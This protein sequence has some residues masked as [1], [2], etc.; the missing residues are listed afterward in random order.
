MRTFGADYENHNNHRKHAHRSNNLVFMSTRVL[1]RVRSDLNVRGFSERGC[2][3][4]SGLIYHGKMLY[5]NQIVLL[6]SYIHPDN[7]RQPRSD[8]PT[9]NIRL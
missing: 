8:N 2:R 5:T 3:V 4:L 9:L 6:P 1:G 7:A